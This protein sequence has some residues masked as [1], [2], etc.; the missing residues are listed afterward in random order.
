M[1]I[2]PILTVLAMCGLLAGAVLR[3]SLAPLPPGPQV[4]A[5]R[6]GFARGAV[7]ALP[8]GRAIDRAALVASLKEAQLTTV[9]LRV[10]SDESGAR[11][12][13]NVS[14]AI[15]LQR[16]LDA[17]I[18]IGTYLRDARAEPT[19]IDSMLAVDRTFLGCYGGDGPRLESTDPTIDKLRLCSADVSRRIVT[20]LAARGASARIG[21]HVPDVPELVDI[22]SDDVRGR[23]AQ[24]HREAA[25]ACTDAK[26]P[27]SMSPLLTRRTV[28]PAR[29]GAELRES[30]TD[31]GVDVYMLQDGVNADPMQSGR[32]GP[33][34][35][36]LRNATVDRVPVQIW[37]NVEAFDCESPACTKTHPTSSSRLIGQLC[38]ARSRVNGIVITEYAHHFAGRP[39]LLGEVPDASPEERAIADDV[40]AAAVLRKGYLEW[41]DAGGPCGP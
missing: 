29:A 34:Y 36:G 11:V 10:S 9:I 40:D 12:E 38:A 26:R 6:V 16:E 25:R 27:V 7:L 32:A 41:R 19:S 31:A 15:E 33:F 17:D 14:L 24:F 30:L 21:C 37:A 20:V 35:Q 28:D 13:E 8:P 39:V 2:R 23:I 22:V 5:T 1:R 3:C 18:L 4:I